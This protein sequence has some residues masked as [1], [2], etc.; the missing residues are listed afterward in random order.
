MNFT[1]GIRSVEAPAGLEPATLAKQLLTRSRH[2]SYGAVCRVAGGY[3]SGAAWG[4]KLCPLV[5]IYHA[6]RRK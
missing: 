6:F 1:M 5:S 2:L 4:M 3:G